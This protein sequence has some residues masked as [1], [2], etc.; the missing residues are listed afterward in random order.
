MKVWTVDDAEIAIRSLEIQGRRIGSILHCT[1]EVGRE[2][3]LIIEV[4]P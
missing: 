2:F 4:A 3:W 1:D